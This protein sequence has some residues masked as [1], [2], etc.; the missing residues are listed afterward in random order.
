[1]SAY[2]LLQ[3]VTI[4][5]LIAVV[6]SIVFYV[7]SFVPMRREIQ[8]LR[9][10]NPGKL[11]VEPSATL[12]LQTKRTFTRLGIFAVCLAAMMGIIL[13]SQRL[14]ASGAVSVP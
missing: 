9:E 13:I 12:R 8:R 10:A 4:L 11:I 14:I 7:L 6:S 5:G 3:A 1:M 2:Q